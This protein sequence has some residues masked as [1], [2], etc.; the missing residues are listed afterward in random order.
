MEIRE[1]GNIILA[2]T[3]MSVSKLGSYIYTFAIG[4]YVLKL[5]G[6]GQTFA[7]TI[8]FGILPRV[9][10]GPFI[11]NLTDRLN[12][13]ILVVGSDIFNGLLMMFL[14]I[15]ALNG[16]LTISIIYGTSVLLAISATF[17]ETAFMAAQRDIVKLETLTRLGSLRQSLDSIINLAS[18]LIG[19]LIYALV[20]ISFFLLIN[21]ISFLLSAFSELFI[22]FKYNKEPSVETEKK[23]FFADMKSG[24]SYFKNESI[25]K[26][27]S[28]YALLL[29][30]F[31]TSM[32][33]VL[34]FALVNI[35]KIED[36][37]YGFIM[38]AIS[39]GALGGAILVGK[40]NS[41]LTS[42]YMIR[43]IFLMGLS[44][45]IMGISMHSFFGSGAIVLVVIGLSGFIMVA[46]ATAINIPMGVFFQTSVDPAYLGRIHSIIGT[47]A[48]AITPLAYII[49]G[50]LADKFSPFMIL[51][52]CG[53]AVVFIIITMINNR[54]LKMLNSIEEKKENISEEMA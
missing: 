3:G 26:S 24:F 50:F 51:T 49:F 42:G 9:I 1:K 17:L 16:E 11:G 48:S 39:L 21:G 10:L 2:V 38:S 54:N 32:S 37:L 33:V 34:P 53:L 36:G 6:S 30:F 45:I 4:L 27:I 14:F 22:N 8:M 31:L 43:T 40:K 28:K 15:Y 23:S 12:K 52:T 18:P 44:F 13:K 20:P 5:T 41:K 29:N 35:L 19:G 47:L 46:S 7:M 25:L